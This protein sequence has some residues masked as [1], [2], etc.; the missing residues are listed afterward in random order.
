MAAKT[1]KLDQSK[2]TVTIQGLVLEQRL[3]FE[4]FDKQP[5][6]SRDGLAAKALL[7]GVLALS[8][9]RL[10]AFL[11]RTT[12]TLGTELE[13]LKFLKAFCF[14]VPLAW[15][16]FLIIQFHFVQFH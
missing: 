12:N 11:S 5:D 4:Y 1:V 13:Q 9:E 3:V 6:A 2:K 15:F 8:E 14:F 16:Q 7:L 10:A